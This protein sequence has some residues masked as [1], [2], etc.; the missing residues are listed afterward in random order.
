MSAGRNRRR[1]RRTVRDDVD[2]VPLA[3][4]LYEPLGRL[5]YLYAL[6][7]QLERASYSRGE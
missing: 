7:V 6:L 5:M 1:R 2:L 3:S 4:L